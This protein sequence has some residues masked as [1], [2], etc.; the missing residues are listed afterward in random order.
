MLML[1]R[2]LAFVIGL[3][4]LGSSDY[5]NEVASD[6]SWRTED[7]IQAYTIRMGVTVFF[8]TRKFIEGWG[9]PYKQLYSFGTSRGMILSKAARP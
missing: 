8:G 7:I 4:Y 3:K 1:I 6:L 5:Q 2:K 9:R